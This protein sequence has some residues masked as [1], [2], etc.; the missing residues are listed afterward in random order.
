MNQSSVHWG[1]KGV[2]VLSKYSFAFALADSGEKNFPF[3]N[4]QYPFREVK[5]KRITSRTTK[6]VKQLYPHYDFETGKACDSILNPSTTVAVL[7]V[8]L[9][10]LLP[11]RRRKEPN[12][13]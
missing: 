11:P 1:T 7:I 5:I 4:C 10:F 12:E 3:V 8:F 9:S 6:P 2:L 13:P